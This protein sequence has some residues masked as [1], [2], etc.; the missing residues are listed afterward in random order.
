MRKIHCFQFV[1]ALALA[2]SNS[3]LFAQTSYV[4]QTATG[5]GI[6][7]NWDNALGAAD[8]ESIVEAG[9]QIYVAEGIYMPG[10][11]IN[12]FTNTTLTGGFPASSTGTDLSLY[13]PIANPTIIDGQNNHKL[14]NNNNVV[15]NL[16]IKGLILQFGNGG[17]GG[18][19]AISA[20]QSGTI[21]F[22]YKYI[23]LTIRNTT[24]GTS[25]AVSITNKNNPNGKVL[26]QNCHFSENT[27][28]RGAALHVSSMYNTNNYLDPNNGNFIIE[29][30]TFVENEATSSGG[31]AIN[32]HSSH[33][34]TIR[35]TSFCDND[36][37]TQNGGAIRYYQCYNQEIIDCDFSGNTA[38][39]DGGAIYAYGT[40]LKMEDVNLVNNNAGITEEGGGI[41]GNANAGIELNNV[42]FYNN[43][44]G[45]GGGIYWPSTF[46]NL[47]ISNTLIDCIFDGNSALE[48]SSHSTAGG[49][50]IKIL[51][52]EWNIQNSTFVNNEVTAD[53]FGGAINV[54]NTGVELTNN[55][56]FNNLVGTFD[57]VPG[58]DIMAYNTNSMFSPMSDNKMQLELAG[59]YELQTGTTQPDSYDFSNDT[60]SNIDDG[61]V[62]MAP[63]I[64]CPSTIFFIPNCVGGLA[65]YGITDGN[66]QTTNYFWDD[67]ATP[68]GDVM[69][70][71]EWGTIRATEACQDGK[72][73]YYANSNEP[74]N[75]LFAIDMLSNTT[76]I[77][78]VEIRVEETPSD[79]YA[80]ASETAT[81]V[82]QRDWHV[83]TVGNAALTSPVDI[84]FYFPPSEY[85][86][87]LDEAIAAATADP[88]S[89]VPTTNDVMWFKKET[90]DPSADINPDAT[91]ITM[92]TGYV[93]MTPL[94]T[95]TALGVADT[96]Y[97]DFGNSKNY[98]EFIN[99]ANFSG[100][101]AFVNILG[102]ALPVEITSF[103]ADVEHCNARLKW[104]VESETNLSHYLVQR[105][106]DGISFET[107][108][109]VEPSQTGDK[110]YEFQNR[111]VTGNL[112]YRLK[113]VD[114]DGSLSYSSTIISIMDCESEL[115]DLSVFPNPILEGNHSINLR[116]H[117]KFEKVINVEVF[118]T[119]G[120]SLMTNSLE[121]S[122]GTNLANVDISKLKA[123]TYWISIK[124]KKGKFL[125]RR[126]MKIRE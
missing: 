77:D 73:R 5:T 97:G 33:Q 38:N 71:Q 92:G 94:N 88:T 24:S 7:N 27:V 22:D 99:I 47:P 96:D 42:T 93:A 101:T 69:L 91:G 41:F 52:G 39:L 63:S 37:T 15:S 111:N 81:Y 8:L 60:F 113:I 115:S 40:E 45:A 23:D 78:Y 125:T 28:G 86:A 59:D 46:N 55:L 70:T 44:A 108:G 72:W 58:S 18:G 51:N 9:G 21:L 13:D 85:Q 66:N 95:P 50:A 89:T 109:L 102:S 34:W 19:G 104:T 20:G 32:F 76:E 26:I 68:P 119:F 17:S 98:V 114:L 29:D 106:I 80:V 61:S 62:P 67:A 75:Y 84:R 4:K 54:Y 16:Q 43:S 116:F 90:F 53:A 57:T 121:A 49:G 117:S 30:C 11:E 110:N 103:E 64:V 2:I 12:I 100:G 118:N 120:M 126:F 79:R 123:G 87:M 65:E 1:I 74:N 56:F 6:G 112:F 82:M 83:Q 105:S 48:N 107:I 122:S 35:R 3:Q 124:G 10:A 14:I 25:G 31:G 36:A